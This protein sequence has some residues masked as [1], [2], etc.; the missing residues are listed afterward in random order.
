VLAVKVGLTT[1]N[2]FFSNNTSA[3]VL[4]GVNGEHRG[5]NGPIQPERLTGIYR[6]TQLLRRCCGQMYNQSC[7][8]VFSTG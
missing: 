1:T 4:K 3:A 7:P 2:P 6:S 8:L 5:Y